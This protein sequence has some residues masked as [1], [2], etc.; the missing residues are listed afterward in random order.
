MYNLQGITGY[1]ECILLTLLV[2]LFLW[3]CNNQTETTGTLPQNP[4]EESSK[5]A[6]ALLKSMIVREYTYVFGRSV[7]TGKV[8]K[9]FQ[10]DKKGNTLPAIKPPESQ[11]YIS[12]DVRTMAVVYDK[13]ASSGTLWKIKNFGN[14]NYSTQQWHGE[15]PEYITKNKK[16]IEFSDPKDSL[17]NKW[18]FK[19]DEQG[20]VVEQIEYT[21]S[22]KIRTKMLYKYFANGNKMEEQEYTMNGAHITRFDKQGNELSEVWYDLLDEPKKQWVYSYE[23]F[24]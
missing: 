8:V 24:N 3:S 20:N 6:S 2:S 1:K 10:Y 16:E 9:S 4:T 22:G 15:K 23:Y 7:G 12:S 18:I 14:R 19:Y 13:G 17:G 21:S 5:S 11:Q